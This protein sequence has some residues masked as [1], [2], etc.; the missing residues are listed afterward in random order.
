MPTASPAVLGQLVESS[1]GIAMLK[2]ELQ[3]GGGAGGIGCR[4]TGGFRAAKL[5][6]KHIHKMASSV[7]PMV[8]PTT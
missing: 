7:S 2:L 1:E 8:P 5:Q 3:S 4:A 6:K